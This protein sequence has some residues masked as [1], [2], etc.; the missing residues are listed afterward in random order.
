MKSISEWRE[1]AEDQALEI[2]GLQLQNEKL[3]RALEE[4]ADT[5][6]MFFKPLKSNPQI[7]REAIEGKSNVR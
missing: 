3:L 2:K 1:F 4:I 6:T 5:A 7:A